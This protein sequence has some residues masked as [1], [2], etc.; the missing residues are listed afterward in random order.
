M[1]RLLQE[2][3]GIDQIFESVVI[4][5]VVHCVTEVAERSTMALIDHILVIKFWKEEKFPGEVF[6]LPAVKD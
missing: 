6:V 4:I 5:G 2:D 1:L 3:L